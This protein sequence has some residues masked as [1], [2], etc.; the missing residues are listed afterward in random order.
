MKMLL[1]L[2]LCLVL[3]FV[4]LLSS[5]TESIQFAE[6][7]G[8]YQDTETPEDL[9]TQ[10]SEAIENT[11]MLPDVTSSSDIETTPE[12][13]ETNNQDGTTG[14]TPRSTPRSTTPRQNANTHSN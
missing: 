10:T 5:C 6:G 14:N 8:L 1:T 4:F 2:S 11:D 3:M 7:F 9:N 13:L 12:T